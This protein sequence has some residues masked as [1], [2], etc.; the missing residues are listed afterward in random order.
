MFQ[1]GFNIFLDCFCRH[2]TS[3]CYKIIACP[4]GRRL[5]QN[6]RIFLAQVKRSNALTFFDDFCRRVFWKS[7]NK[8][9]N[10]IGLNGKFLYLP[11]A[12]FTFILYESTAIICYI[13][14]QNR[15]S[16]LGCPDQMI[17]DQVYPVF[18]SLIFH[19]NTT[20]LC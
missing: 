4:K 13:T 7:L 15:L 12:L 11:A 3:G 1:S 8:Q 19:K 17:D 10:M 5:I 6:S 9:M 14:N 20:N 16:A 18:I 2:I